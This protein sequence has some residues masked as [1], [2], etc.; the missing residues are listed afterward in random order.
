MWVTV[1]VVLVLTGLLGYNVIFVGAEGY[2]TTIV[3]GGLLGGYAGVN[4]L[5]KGKSKGDD[6]K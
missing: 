1:L 4:Q 5:L 2:P 6:E 3:I